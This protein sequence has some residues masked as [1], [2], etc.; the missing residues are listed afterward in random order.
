M[1]FTLGGEMT[2]ETNPTIQ[3]AA[4]SKQIGQHTILKDIDLVVPFGQ[5]Y[6][7]SGHNGAGKSMLLRVLCGL[8]RPSQGEVKVFGEHIGKEAEFPK[9]TGVLIERPG[10]LPQYSSMKNL[11]LLAMIRGSITRDKIAQ[12]IRL[13]GLEVED[14]RPVRTY[15]TGMRQRLGIAQAIM[16]EPEL[17]LLD[18]PT[19]ALDREGVAEI[20][21]LLKTLKTKGVTILLT[22][23]NQEEIHE[24]CDA[25]FIMERGS[26]SANA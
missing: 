3:V 8:V 24:L 10:F 4:L 9:N 2:T 16:E 14:S 26:L 6:G 20:H 23:H 19:N 22:S 15:S 5:I 25:A 21:E 1:K 12:T 18:E 11:E 13:V 17:L 7:I